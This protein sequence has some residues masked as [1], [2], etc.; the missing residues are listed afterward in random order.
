MSIPDYETLMLPVLEALSDGQE[1]HLRD[2]ARQAA[3]RF[4]LTD[5]ECQRLLPSGQQTIILNR[6]SWA[7]TY[8]K[9]SGLVISTSRGRVKITDEGRRVLAQTPAKID[10]HFLSQYPS[11]V[12]FK[13]TRRTESREDA[14]VVP[15]EA[16]QTPEEAI[17]AAY[18]D[19]RAALADE[20]LERVR[21][22]SPQFFERLV[23]ELLV[24]MGYGG[25][26]KDAGRA[27]GRT[28][29]EGI[30]GIIKEDKLGLDVVCI[31]A[32]RWTNTVGRPEVQAFA[33][34]MEGHRAKKGVMLTT[35]TFSKDAQ[36]YISRIER[37]IVLIDGRQLAELM[38]DHGIGTT[39]SRTYDIR[40]IDSDYFADD[41]G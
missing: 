16:D 39:T 35:A 38:I 6:V 7:R 27:V 41:G 18:R 31:Q 40:R 4:G 22:C 26:L 11:Y 3:E 20:V 19:L 30:D 17:E 8:L 13:Q 15:A 9:K 14:D 25:S 29:D 33:G 28:G 37:K 32:K 2:V 1:H 34:S 10:T 36:D 24:A 12:E 5:E 21:A 23:V